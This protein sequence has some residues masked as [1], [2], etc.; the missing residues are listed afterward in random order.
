MRQV[1]IIFFKQNELI[2]TT[3]ETTTESDAPWRALH[4]QGK[5]GVAGGRDKINN[6]DKRET[7][8]ALT[9]LMMR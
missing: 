8:P 7:K 6:P 3:K 1:K 5:N 4:A 9:G 2:S